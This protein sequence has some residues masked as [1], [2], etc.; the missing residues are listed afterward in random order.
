MRWWRGVQGSVKL[1]FQFNEKHC[2]EFDNFILEVIGISSIILLNNL[3]LFKFVGFQSCFC[4]E[5]FLCFLIIFKLL[6]LG[7]WRLLLP[8]AISFKITLPIEIALFH[9]THFNWWLMPTRRHALNLRES[10]FRLWMIRFAHI[11][12]L[13]IV[14]VLHGLYMSQVLVEILFKSWVSDCDQHVPYVFS[15]L[16]REVGIFHDVK[17]EL[18]VPH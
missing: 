8:W 16:L 5:L 15:K 6:F 2:E 13:R 12:K 10:S 14:N 7:W 11:V 1:F 18:K 9:A 17:E 4:K 3:S